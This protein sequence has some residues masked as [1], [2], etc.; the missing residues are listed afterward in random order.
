MTHRAEVL[1]PKS[2]EVDERLGEWETVVEARSVCA[3][4]EGST[5]S[6]SQPWEGL[7]KAEGLERWYRV[8]SR[9]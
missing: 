5:L 8:I 7:G 9:R 3:K 2:D 1:L 6:W 4:H